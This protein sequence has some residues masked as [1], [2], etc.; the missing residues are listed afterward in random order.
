MAHY[1]IISP[2]GTGDRGEV[3]S[4]RDTRQDRKLLRTRIPCPSIPHDPHP[5]GSM[6]RRFR[7][8]IN[9]FT[10]LQAPTQGGRR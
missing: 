1:E 4:A 3:H 2:I 5:E 10:E 7:V 9:W 8:V 6:P